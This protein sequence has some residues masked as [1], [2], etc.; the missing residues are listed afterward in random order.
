M[1]DLTDETGQD[2]HAF[3]SAY[4]PMYKSRVE[5]V[6]FFHDTQGK[7]QV[8]CSVET[9]DDSVLMVTFRPSELRNFER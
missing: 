5:I 9:E 7:V 3:R 4:S 6:R 1:L 8:L 2:M